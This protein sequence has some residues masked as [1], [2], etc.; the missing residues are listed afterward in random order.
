MRESRSP[1]GSF[2]DMRPSLPAR[3]HEAGDEALGTE[4]A[5]RDAAHLELAVKGARTAGDLAAIA[6]ADLRGVARQF[7]ELQRRR[8][9]LFHG[10]GL[11]HRNLLQPRAAS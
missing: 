9:A 7:R 11:V 5:Q 4:L 3:L 6:H 1:S 2:I 10:H 8:E